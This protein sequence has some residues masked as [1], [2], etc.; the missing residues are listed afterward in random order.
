MSLWIIVRGGG[1]LASGVA[2]RLHRAGL[3]VMI[4]ELPQPLVV[5]RAVAFADAIY[6]REI[7]VEGVVA[8]LAPTAAPK[9]A[10]AAALEL[11]RQGIIPVLVDPNADALEALR[12]TGT[13]T[14]LVDARM[15][16]RP[17]D[18]G[19][20]AA[21]LV[22]GL[23][24]GFTAG[25]DCDAVIETNRGHSLGRVIWSGP[26]E[27]DT[28]VPEGVANKTSERVLRA[29]RAGV[30]ESLAEIGQHV[31]A[32]QIVARVGGADVLAIFPGVVRGLARS[33]LHVGRGDKIGDID[34]R[35]NPCYCRLVS[36][37]ALAVGGGVLEALLARPGL[38]PFLWDEDDCV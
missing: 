9:N 10:L 22:I 38:R 31:A 25:V 12:S 28:G 5:R 32:G 29:P 17:P 1:D 37:K 33:G 30:L 20:G 23:G 8:R 21:D 16:K 15:L 35:D 14:V 19:K 3:H 36:D 7:T 4:T 24:P 11:H 27:A 6:E 26:A 2:L 13:P 34:P 18:L